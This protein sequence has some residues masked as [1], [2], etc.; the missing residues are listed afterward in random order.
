MIR[1]LVDSSSDFPMEEVIEKNMI[2]VPISIT[3]GEKSYADGVDISRDAFYELLMKSGEFPKTSQ[4]SPQDFADI[5][6]GAKE[7]G[8]EVICL[9]LSSGLSGTCQS[10]HL[11]KNMVEYEGIHIVD[12]LAATVLIKVMADYA[13][14]LVQKGLGAAQIVEKLEMLK[15]KVKVAASLDTLEYLQRGGRIGKAAAALGEMAS[16]KPIITILEDGTI[17]MLGK[18][19]GKN[20]AIQFLRKHIAA[21]SIDPEFPVYTVFTYGTTNC[22][23]LEDK[24]SQD[25]VSVSRRMQIGATIGTHVGPGVC[26]VVY[27]EK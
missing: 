7:N 2:F 10:A 15:S 21:A 9:L 13:Y 12:S 22:E 19:I 26:G 5:F 11:A 20:K 25:G 16:L 4:P 27:V 6:E 14:D 3:F 17:G 24:L 23:L 8:D 18:C 1:I